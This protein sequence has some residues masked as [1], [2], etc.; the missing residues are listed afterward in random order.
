MHADADAD[1]KV[2]NSDTNL[3]ASDACGDITESTIH[4]DVHSYSSLHL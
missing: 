4:N 2:M 3:G 1:M